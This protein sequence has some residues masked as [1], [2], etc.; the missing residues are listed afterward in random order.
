LYVPTNVG[1]HASLD[2]DN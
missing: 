1:V 2:D